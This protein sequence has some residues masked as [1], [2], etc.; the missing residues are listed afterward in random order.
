M[1]QATPNVTQEFLFSSSDQTSNTFLFD[2]LYLKRQNKMMVKGSG[3]RQ[4]PNFTSE[5]VIP[6]ERVLRELNELIYV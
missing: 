6:N 3:V 4:Y 5:V 2:L 1:V